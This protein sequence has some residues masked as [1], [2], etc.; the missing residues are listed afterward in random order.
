MR[1]RPHVGLRNDNSFGPRSN[2]DDPDSF[3]HECTFAGPNMGWTEQNRRPDVRSFEVGSHLEMASEAKIVV[4]DVAGGLAAKTGGRLVRDT[5]G[6]LGADQTR[7]KFLDSHHNLCGFLLGLRRAE[8][9]LRI[10][11]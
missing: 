1:G 4:F 10:K 7:R 11:I 6:L 3:P 2:R 5:L 9:L 8:R